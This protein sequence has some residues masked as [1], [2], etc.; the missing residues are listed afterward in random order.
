MERKNKSVQLRVERNKFNNVINIP[1]RCE[2]RSP[3]SAV[4]VHSD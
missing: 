4:S 1:A 2:A 3:E